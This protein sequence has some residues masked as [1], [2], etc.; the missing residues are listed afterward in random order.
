MNHSS[1]FSF[2]WTQKRFSVISAGTTH[3]I[4]VRL[5]SS[6]TRESQLGEHCKLIQSRLSITFFIPRFLPNHA[7]GDPKAAAPTFDV[8]LRTL[9]VSEALPEITYEIIGVWKSELNFDSSVTTAPGSLDYQFDIS[10]L[11][12]ADFEVLRG[13]RDFVMHFQVESLVSLSS[14]T[15]MFSTNS[16]KSHKL[17]YNFSA[18]DWKSFL[19]QVPNFAKVPL[20][21]ERDPV[22]SEK[23]SSV[24]LEDEE[25]SIDDVNVELRDYEELLQRAQ[26][27]VDQGKWQQAMG[28]CHV[29]AKQMRK[30]Y[31]DQ[32][33]LRKG[34]AALVSNDR[35]ASAIHNT[36]K[37]IYQLTKLHSS[38][39]DCN[40]VDCHLVIQQLVSLRTWY[41]TMEQKGIMTKSEANLIY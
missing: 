35:K 7:F 2:A 20:L 6:S 22:L 26:Q 15:S 9:S 32:G 29:F 23:T 5:S 13:N 40:D 12:L 34:L 28:V 31:E 37:S 30:D 25:A 10:R 19:K 8:R 11:N 4:C 3:H 38:V 36:L 27:L 14:K 24:L 18:S 17:E 39:D 41:L 16:E 1:Y 33:Q 21:K